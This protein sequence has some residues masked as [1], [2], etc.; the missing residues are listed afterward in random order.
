[1]SDSQELTLDH[2]EIVIDEASAETD[3]VDAIAEFALAVVGN[4]R[5]LEGEQATNAEDR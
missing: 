2:F 3:V 4:R 1:M 5:R